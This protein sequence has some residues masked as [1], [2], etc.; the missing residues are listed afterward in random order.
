M[1]SLK[2]EE[3][4]LIDHHIPRW[5]TYDGVPTQSYTGELPVTYTVV[6]ESKIRDIL[7]TYLKDP[8]LTGYSRDALYD[9]VVRDRWLGISKRDVESFLKN[10]D[11]ISKSKAS[12]T[13]PVIKSYRPLFPM[14]HWQIDLIEMS[15]QSIVEANQFYRFLVVIIDIFSKFVYIY[16]IQKKEPQFVASILNR[17]F[18][19]G[20]IPKIIQHDDGSEFKG[21]VTKLLKNF[22]IK[23][24]SNLPYSPQ[25]NGFVENKNKQVKNM[26]QT[27]MATRRTKV[28][29]NII[30]RVAFNI[31]N[32]KHS[33]TR[34]TP[35]QVHRGIDINNK[36]EKLSYSL[37]PPDEDIIDE[38][39]KE[40][41]DKYVESAKK[42]YDRRIGLVK[43][44]IHR[45]ADKRERVEEQNAFTHP[46]VIG[47]KVHVGLKQFMNPGIKPIYISLKDANGLTVE[48]ANP[49]NVIPKTVRIDK[50]TPYKM[51]EY[52][53]TVDSIV[54][55]GNKQYYILSIIRDNEKLFVYQMLKPNVFSN[56]MYRSQIYL[57]KNPPQYIPA[58]EFPYVD[59]D[60][61]FITPGN[62]NTPRQP[63]G[64]NNA[65]RQSPGNNNAPRQ[66]PGNNNAP[67]QSPGNNNAP[68]Q[69]PGNNNTPRERESMQKLST[70]LTSKQA[71]RLLNVLRDGIKKYAPVYV[72]IAFV[73]V[74]KG[75]IQT[76]DGEIVKYN[77]R[78]TVRVYDPED[79]DADRDGYFYVYAE[80]K[81]TL[82]K[83][84]NKENGWTFSYPDTI[85]KD[86]PHIFNPSKG[87]RP[88]PR[89]PDHQKEISMNDMKKIMRVI[90]KDR[91]FGKIK[92]KRPH[93]Y[94]NVSYQI[95]RKKGFAYASFTGYLKMYFPKNTRIPNI[96]PGEAVPENKTTGEFGIWIVEYD[97]DAYNDGVQ[98]EY[99]S[100]HPDKYAKKNVDFGWSFHNPVELRKQFSDVLS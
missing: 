29:Y 96:I 50:K 43:G 92:E 51:Y 32:T 2:D 25:T 58:R 99:V 31:N 57:I 26:I 35:F 27:Y 48:S 23:D 77:K 37:D 3:I 80:L 87:G 34:M 47:D 97:D 54:K 98:T 14:Q 100:L 64:N 89:S 39:Q 22:N 85:R 6:K 63:P 40:L 33:V 38:E 71:E 42:S 95:K 15:E 70:A 24:I 44:I 68:R 20:D 11:L 46:I 82:Y 84:M 93:V 28:Y 59:P 10:T 7:A 88:V 73:H 45:V 65:P 8:M 91:T 86:F 1:Y 19:N 90:E 41:I 56:K 67:R 17:I 36:V 72:K 21:S 55:Q 4:V 9:K 83:V 16:P 5:L 74:N 76:I 52:E 12:F 78:W 61:P 18:L 81:S 69:P 53:F 79:E 75:T 62:N 49:D 30:D 13:A 66:P 94:V 60:N